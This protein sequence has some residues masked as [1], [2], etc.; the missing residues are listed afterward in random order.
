MG[1]IRKYQAFLVSDAIKG[2]LQ[3]IAEDHLQAGKKET[4]C[5]KI[6]NYTEHIFPLFFISFNHHLIYDTAPNSIPPPPVY[7]IYAAYAV[8]HITPP[9][10]SVET[11]GEEGKVF[12]PPPPFSQTGKLHGV[13]STV[14]FNRLRT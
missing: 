2:S 9:F 12:L 6:V 5:N 3:G 14:Q 1:N 10:V 8:T 4:N 11:G 7:I 13:H